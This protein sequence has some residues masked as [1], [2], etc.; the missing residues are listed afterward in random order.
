[1]PTDTR[2]QL[3]TEAE[4]IVRRV[5]YAGFSYADLADR[6]GLRK[7][8][9]HHHFP[10]KED[11][12]VALVEG[13]T[14]RFMA[15]LED[16]AATHPAA[17]DRLRAYADL[18]RAG[19]ADGVCCLCGVLAAELAGLPE[20]VRIGLRRFFSVATTWLIAT[21]AEGQGARTLRPELDAAAQAASV[22]AMFQGAL[23][24]ASAQGSAASFD[25][26]AGAILESLMLRPL[27]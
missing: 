10:T 2:T 20:R 23:L 11:L 26:A 5:G 25:A 4:T 7:A 24:V 6:V 22:V 18:H 16:A 21:I 3:L 12:G 1:M 13:Y 14:A 17:P 19:L 27:H 9:I 15:A 8:S